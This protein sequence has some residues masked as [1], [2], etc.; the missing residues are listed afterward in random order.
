MK[1]PTHRRALCLVVTLFVALAALAALPREARADAPPLAEALT[2]DAK[3]DYERAKL[4][5]TDGDFVNAYENFRSAYERAHDA[6]LLWNMAACEKNRRRYAK[7]LVLVRRYVLEASGQLGEQDRADAAELVKIIE[8][9]TGTLQVAVS[10]PG[11]EVSV[12]GEPLGKSPTA[13]VLVDRGPRKV[14]VTKP[15]FT[16]VEI[17]HRLDMVTLETQ[18]APAELAVN[19]LGEIRIRTAKPLFYDGYASNRLTGSFILI[20]QG[21]NATV[22]AGMLLPPT[23]VVRPENTDYVI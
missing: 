14:R 12:D 6:R 11:A 20:E 2:G 13:P 7:T 3:A 1:P 9:L 8:P 23:E 19:D 15:D 16:D 4:L 18:P 17:E 22:A 10:E 21:T 5:Y